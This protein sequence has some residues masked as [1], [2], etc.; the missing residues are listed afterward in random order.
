MDTEMCG[1]RDIEIHRC[2]Q[3]SRVGGR[4]EKKKVMDG[5][6][7]YGLRENG[8]NGYGQIGRWGEWIE[9]TNIDRVDRVD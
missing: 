8:Q 5:F 2:G 4:E 7:G 3:L 1:Y 9:W 6:R